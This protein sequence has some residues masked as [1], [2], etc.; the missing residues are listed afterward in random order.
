MIIKV[1]IVIIMAIIITNNLGERRLAFELTHHAN[2]EE[3][4]RRLTVTYDFIIMF[5]LLIF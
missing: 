3:T 1:T 4:V 2:P 5:I